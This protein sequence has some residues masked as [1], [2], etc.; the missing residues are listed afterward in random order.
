MDFLPLLED[1][2]S[3]SLGILLGVVDH[4]E[5]GSVLTL[6]NTLFHHLGELM[7]ELLNCFLL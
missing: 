4:L 7:L 3:D 2:L 1:I 6:P 5:D